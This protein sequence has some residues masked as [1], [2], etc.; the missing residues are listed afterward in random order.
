M[1]ADTE[2][3]EVEE[4]EEEDEGEVNGEA[5]IHVLMIGWLRRDIQKT[6]I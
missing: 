6:F 2:K 4:E 5:R 3:I 1:S